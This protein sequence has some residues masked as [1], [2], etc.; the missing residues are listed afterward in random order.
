MELSIQVLEE[1]KLTELYQY[2]KEFDIPN[3]A[4]MT[5]K[6]LIFAILKLQTEKDGLL[7]MEG[8][9]DILAD[10]FGFLRPINYLPSDEDIYISVSIYV[11]AIGFRGRRGRLRK[12]NAILACCML[13]LLMG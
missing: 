4:K 2:A 7:F 10:G 6:E 3:F 8:V 13:M 11:R 9:L 12:M 5:K 1:K